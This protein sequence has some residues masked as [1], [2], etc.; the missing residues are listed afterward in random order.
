MAHAAQQLLLSQLQAGE[1]TWNPDRLTTNST[2]WH[3]MLDWPQPDGG[4][5]DDSNDSALAIEFKPPGH[6]KR[7]YVT[8]L[9]QAHTYLTAFEFSL[10][11]VPERARDSFPIADFLAK[12]LRSSTPSAAIGLVAYGNDPG[13][14]SDLRTVVR[15]PERITA[16]PAIP[17]SS[18]RKVFWA[19]WR[20]LSPFD[21]FTIVLL[22]DQGRSFDVAFDRFWA[23]FWSVG[24]AR[25]WEGNRRQPHASSSKEAERV[26][27]SLSL[28]QIGAVGSDGQLTDEGLRLVQ[29]GKVYGHSSVAFRNLLGQMVLLRGRHLD[30]IFWVEDQQRRLLPDD[31]FRSQAHKRAL[32][33]QLQV[34]GV[35][36]K[37][38][39]A[40]GKA[41]F[42]RDEFKLWNKLGLLKGRSA[43]QYFHPHV[44]LVFNWRAIISLANAL[45]TREIPI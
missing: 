9:G 20:D 30:L 2:L 16:A 15:V 14:P 39:T 43:T 21:A 7:E 41:T 8:G 11:I 28:R 37:L 18:N 34:A 36:P 1:A 24:E 29:T 3:G 45:P 38:P 6:S 19:Y 26:N 23:K 22:M 5:Q 32:D 25:D 40:Q 12:T 27:T 42:L 31:L 33:K 35:I 44:G 10:L 17:R 13:K 4:F